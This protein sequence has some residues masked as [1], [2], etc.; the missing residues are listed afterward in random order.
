MIRFRAKVGMASNLPD[1]LDLA[2]GL[3]AVEVLI[4]HSYQLLFEEQLPGATHDGPIVLVYSVIWA[5]SGHGVA[6]V[7]VF[8]VLSGYLVGGPALVRAKN[9]ELNAIDYFSA[10]ASRLYVVLLPALAVSLLFYL[11]ATQSDKWQ[12]FVAFHQHILAASGLFSSSVSPAAALCN[13]LFL[14]TIACSTYAGNLALW[15]LSNEFW[16]YVLIFAL[17]S[18]GKRPAWILAIVVILAL[19]V[20]AERADVRG[21]HTG[22]KFTFYFLIWCVGAL[23]YAVVLP[24]RMWLLGLLISLAGIYLLQ[25]KGLLPGWAAYHLTVSI[26]TAAAILGIEFTRLSLP[27]S[28]YF[29]RDI[30]KWSFSLYAIH[31]PILVF[32]NVSIAAEKRE[33]TIGSLALD[34]LFI[35]CGLLAAFIF[36]LLFE[37]HTDAV[38]ARLRTVI[39]KRPS[40]PRMEK[41]LAP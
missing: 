33:F 39:G 27:S 10:R 24:L 16:Y 2:R 15:S 30:A 9:G 11:L 26:L 13:G 40:K 7:I 19:F 4:F 21:Y 18:V 38:R 28:L 29:A 25:A 20:V 41:S 17:L 3:A 36:Y 8:F 22:L 31:Y 37:R 6:A 14:Q 5:L 34:M 12:P 23:V 32:L 35:L 1:W